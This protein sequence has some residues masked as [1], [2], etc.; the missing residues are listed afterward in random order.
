MHLR[1]ELLAGDFPRRLQFSEWF[2]QRCRRDN[3]LNSFIIGDEAAF[4]MNGE[5]NI[6]NVRQYAPKGQPLSFNFERNDSR[7][8]LTVCMGC[9]LRQ[10]DRICLTEK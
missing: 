4:S 3:F 8:K 7:E 9:T 6:H 2:N 1:H 5:V 10:W